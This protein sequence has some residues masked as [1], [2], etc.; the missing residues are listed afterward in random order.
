MWFIIFSNCLF[1][2]LVKFVYNN[3]YQQ[4]HPSHTIENLKLYITAKSKT[5]K[6]LSKYLIV[7]L[8]LQL[9][10]KDIPIK[11]AT[12]LFHKNNNNNTWKQ[13]KTNRDDKYIL[14]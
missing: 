10:P 7:G 13:M 4:W 8:F 14:K 5:R 11:R 12:I 6:K 3:Y 2:L 1:S 9:N